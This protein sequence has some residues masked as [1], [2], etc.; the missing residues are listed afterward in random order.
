MAGFCAC[1]VTFLALLEVDGPARSTARLPF[2]DDKLRSGAPVDSGDREK[3]PF[4]VAREI[5]LRWVFRPILST[6]FTGHF[7]IAIA[8]SGVEAEARQLRLVAAT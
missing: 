4:P 6:M 7:E 2:D 8:E 5:L 3:L 1:G